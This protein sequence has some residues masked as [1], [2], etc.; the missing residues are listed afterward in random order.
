[1]KWNLVGFERYRIDTKQYR[2]CSIH[3]YKR[4]LESN[5]DPNLLF[6]PE[7]GSEYKIEET[8]IDQTIE[9]K[10]GTAN[11]TKIVSAKSRRK[12]FFDSQ[13][14]E[15]NQQDKDIMADLAQGKTVISYSEQNH[16][17]SKD[18]VV[19]IGKYGKVSWT[20]LL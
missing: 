16:D 7:C 5:T 18:K 6:C 17:E 15:I 1:M 19:S 12:R 13:G 20:D 8:S 10:F 4:L 14:N 3:T 9:S 11:Q 2:H